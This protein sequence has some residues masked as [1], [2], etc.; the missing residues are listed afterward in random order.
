PPAE[1]P[2]QIQFTCSPLPPPAIPPAPPITPIDTEGAIMMRWGI[3]A[4]FGGLVVTS[5]AAAQTAAWQFRWKAGTTLAYRVEQATTASEEVGSNKTSSTTKLNL[6]KRWQV[7][8]VDAAGVATLQLSL[9]A[10]RLETTTPEGETLLFDSANLDKSSPQLR[11]QMGRYV[12]QPLAVL[13]IDGRGQVVEVKDS[14]FGPANR[15]Q[16]ELPF[17]ITLPEKPAQPG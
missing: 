11:E 1:R 4:I 10:L 8:Q 14:K 17:A 16:N 15:Y 7:L 12:G 13:R 3:L 9:D 5:T 2:T 6:V